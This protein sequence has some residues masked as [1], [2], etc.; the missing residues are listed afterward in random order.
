VGRTRA[1]SM[2]KGGGMLRKT[3]LAAMM[4][5][6][7]GALALDRYW[8]FMRPHILGPA[9]PQRHAGAATKPARPGATRLERPGLPN[10]FQVTKDFYRGAQPTAEGVRSLKALGVRTIVNLRQLHSD[11]G[12]IGDTKIGYVHITVNTLD[13]DDKDVVGFLRVVGDP[14]RLPVFVHCKRGIDRTGLMTAVYRIAHC[15]WSKADAIRE[16]REGPFGYDGVFKNVVDYLWVADVDA[17]RKQASDE[18]PPVRG[19]GAK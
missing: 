4:L 15:G 11:R 12:A 10:F 5:V 8:P 7:V 2:T 14:N 13:P 3:L 19:P 1:G 9:A 17:L 6:P 18:K 16:M